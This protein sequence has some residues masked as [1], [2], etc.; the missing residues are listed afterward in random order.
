MFLQLQHHHLL[1]NIR[2]RDW[3]GRCSNPHDGVS[4]GYPTLTKYNTVMYFCKY[5][6]YIYYIYLYSN[7][8]GSQIYSDAMIASSATSWLRRKKRLSVDIHVLRLR[9]PSI[10]DCVVLAASKPLG[11]PCLLAR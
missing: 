9:G 3:G 5:N 4:P 8:A 11:M 10:S 2:A 7:I 1:A 6:Q